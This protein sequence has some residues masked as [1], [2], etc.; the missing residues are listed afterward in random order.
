MCCNFLDAVTSKH[1]VP[2]CRISPLFFALGRGKRSFAASRST[3]QDGAIPL[4]RILQAK[5]WAM[6]N[7][8]W[9]DHCSYERPPSCLD[10]AG[11]GIRCGAPLTGH[12]MALSH[13]T[14]PQKL[15]R[16]RKHTSIKLSALSIVLKCVCTIASPVTEAGKVLPQTWW[17]TVLGTVACLVSGKHLPPFG[18]RTVLLENMTDCS[19]MDDSEENQWTK[20][21]FLSQLQDFWKVVHSLPS[22]AVY[23]QGIVTSQSNHLGM[24]GRLSHEF[25]SSDV[26]W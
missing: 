15:A 2:S 16:K 12:A 22:N 9:D 7:K 13:T 26:S 3:S 6:M 24:D 17:A 11:N 8:S 1:P 19:W 20:K 23:H 25:R 10:A 5:K 14:S 21:S 18:T 4:A